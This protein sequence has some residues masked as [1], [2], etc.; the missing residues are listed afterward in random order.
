MITEIEEEIERI[1]ME[2]EARGGPS[3]IEARQMRNL[4]QQL[5][6]ATMG[7]Q[8]ELSP[9]MPPIDLVITQSQTVLSFQPTMTSHLGKYTSEELVNITQKMMSANFLVQC[10]T[11][12]KLALKKVILS[13]K[14]KSIEIRDTFLLSFGQLKKLQP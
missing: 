14:L 12:Q 11:R 4:M 10:S 9:Q 7:L 2:T 3:S 13:S 6:E 1:E 5:K 8:K